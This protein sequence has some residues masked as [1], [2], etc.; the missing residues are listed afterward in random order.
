MEANGN[1]EQEIF[2]RALEC[3]SGTAR[4]AYLDKACAHNPPLRK[5]VE[6]L[7][8]SHEGAGEFLSGS[9]ERVGPF[10]ACEAVQEG[11]DKVISR[12]QLLQKIGEGGF[13]VV[14]MAEQR[15]P[16][17]RR[18]AL[19]VIKLGMDTRQVV[20]RFEAERQ[21]L[22]LMDH[23]NIATV[24]DGGATETGR[25][26]FVMELVRGV[27]ITEFCDDHQVPIPERLH[28]FEEVC[29]AIHHAHQ[30]GVIHRDIKPSNVLVTLQE[31]RVVS[32]VIDF[33]VAKA[34]QQDLSANAV[35]TRYHELIGTPAYM[36]PE[37]ARMMTLDIDTRTDIYSLGVLLYELLTGYTPFDGRELVDAGF[38]EMRRRIAQG[39]PPRPSA[40][41]NALSPDQRAEIARH[42]RTEP[43]RLARRLRGELDW[44]VLKA[45]EKDRSRRYE[46]ASALAHEVQCYLEN[47]P[48]SAAAPGWAYQFRKFTCRHRSAVLMAS[49]F[50]LLLLAAV[51]IS[52]YFGAKAARAEHR[53]RQ[54][55]EL[56]EAISRFMTED[57][58]AQTDPE[59]EPDREL[60]VRTLLDRAGPQIQARFERRPLVEATI[61]AT[62]GQIYFK[63]GEFT[64][65]EHHL[66][67]AFE[68]RFHE[69]G[70]THA[71][72][73]AA[74]SDLAMN[75]LAQRQ[76]Q[77]ARELS[78]SAFHLAQATF[79]QRQ[80]QTLK[81][82]SRYSWTCFS[83]GDIRIA[84]RLARDMLAAAERVRGVAP[85]DKAQAMHVL[86]R[87]L[88]R[89]GQVREGEQLLRDACQLLAHQ[90]GD[91]DPRTALAKNRIAAYLYDH[92]YDLAQ[93]E[94]LYLEAL[95]EHR[96]ILGESHPRTLAIR[97][98]LALLYSL[99]ERERPANALAQQLQILEHL[100]E[101]QFANTLND[102]A[103]LVGKANLAPIGPSL[104]LPEWRWISEP[105]LSTWMQPAFDDHPWLRAKAPVGPQLWLRAS[106]VL[107][108]LPES[109]PLL[110]FHN[111]GQL[112]L[113]L[114]GCRVPRRLWR[115]TERFQ[116]VLGDAQT[117]ASLR[118]GTN[119]V[120][121]HAQGIDPETPLRMQILERPSNR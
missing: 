43:H 46:S 34:T 114:N 94:A 76:P 11:P 32:K 30:K 73:I 80:P 40:R 25:P 3:E 62:V 48:I 108:Q 74:M 87:V 19:K 61:H 53:A 27:P 35:L 102:F 65:A 31:G 113:F 9:T 20:A 89:H 75:R 110:V 70:E 55:A 22:A 69:L 91:A 51:I 4:V 59:V 50:L 115:R 107:E 68:L 57:L 83:A 33:G 79:G 77:D 116:L 67:R 96:R 15:E 49:A 23:P 38:D 93:A 58:F 64:R 37:Q 118:L 99:P 103:R 45:L 36:S 26:Y 44:I 95:A 63:L 86:G 111:T 56:A 78:D 28:L 109:P 84:E 17:K 66:N 47:R 2:G 101:P 24:L 42:R 121:I 112:E 1:N 105:P 90:F 29:N 7:L 14:Y 72:T 85:E 100:T 82:L 10:A 8:S 97:G 88:G 71:D 119:T 41:L 60:R 81:Y 12:Y 120:S 106:L 13:G 92:R 54:Q 21:A 117:L 39:E 18:V 6:N 52:T 16:V 5:R 104:S 98:N